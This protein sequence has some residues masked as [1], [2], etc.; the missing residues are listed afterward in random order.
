[1]FGFVLL[2]WYVHYEVICF[3]M[4]YCQQFVA[5]SII[6][7]G[8][9]DQLRCLLIRTFVSCWSFFSLTP[10][11]LIYSKVKLSLGASENWYYHILMLPDS[12]IY[13]CSRLPM[14]L[15]AWTFSCRVGEASHPGPKTIRLC[16]TNPTAIYKKVSDLVKFGGDVILASETSATIAVQST[17]QFEFAK[18]N[19]KSYFS[20]HVASK[21]ETSDLRPSFRGEP[22]GTAIFSKLP[23]RV[24]RVDIP[25]PLWDSQRFCCSIVRFGQLEVC[26]VSIYGFQKKTQNGKKVNDILLSY[27]YRVVKEIGLPYIISGDFNEPVDQ[28]PIFNLFRE[29][30]ATEAFY[31]YKCQTQVTLPPTCKGVTRNDSA[32]LHPLI[33]QR[34]VGMSVSEKH[35]IDV[36]SPLFVELDFEN[37]IPQVLSWKIPKSWAAMAPNKDLFAQ[38]YDHTRDKHQSMF[39]QPSSPEDIDTQLQHWSCAVEQAVD[40]AIQLQHKQ[41]PLKY[42]L[43]CLPGQ[44]KGRCVIQEL[45][46]RSSKQSC[47]HDPHGNFNPPSEV[48]SIRNKQKTRQVRRLKSL[49]RAYKATSVQNGLNSQDANVCWQ[50]QQEWFA[51][52]KARGYG[53]RWDHW[54]LSFELVP[55]VP[56]HLPEYSLLELMSDI[57]MY[58]C[59][60]SCKYETSQ[61]KQLF[62]H[63]IQVDNEHDFGKMTYRIMKSKPRASLD[64]VPMTCKAHGTLLRCAKGLPKIRIHPVMDL[65]PGSQIKYGNCV[66]K[67][68]KSEH[69]IVTISQLEG[70]VPAQGE[71]QFTKVA[72]T[73]TEIY[74]TFK[75]F[76][77]PMWMRDSYE[78]QFSPQ[79][80]NDFTEELNATALPHIPIEAKINDVSIW[81]DVIADLKS[82]K[83]HGA[84]G[85]RHEELK[86]LPKNA[87][88]DLACIFEQAMHHGLSTN[89]MK[90]R[91]ILLAKV[92]VPQSMHHARPITILGVLY[93]LVGKVIFKQIAKQMSYVLPWPISGGLP[94]RGVKDIAYT[95]KIVIEKSLKNQLQL[96]GFSL[97]LVKAFNTFGRYP[98]AQI[99]I[100]LGIPVWIVSFW[101]KSL[102][103]M[104]RYLDHGGTMSQAIPV[105]TG[106]PEGDS[107]SVLA[108]LS[109]SAFYYYRILREGVFPYAYADNWSWF[110]PCQRLHFRTFTC[111]LNMVSCLKLTIDFDKSWH[112]GTTKAFR[113]ACENFALLFP[114]QNIQTTVK[115]QV[116]D[117]GEMVNYNKSVS[118]GFIQDKF[119]E[120]VKVI[121]R[122]EWIPCSI[123]QKL[124]RIQ[125][126]A[127]PMAL[128]STDTT[129]V[130]PRHF[131]A[132]RRA[133][134]QAL[135]G[136]KLNA[137][138]WLASFVLSKTLQDPFLHVLCAITRCVRR[139][140]HTDIA[141]AK[142]IVSMACDFDKTR[143]YGPASA[144]KKYLQN[145][146]WEIDQDG[147]IYGPDHLKTNI[148]TDS[149]KD[150]KR[151]LG[152]GW[153]SYLIQNMDRKGVGDVSLHPQITASVFQSFSEQDQKLLIHN[154]LG[155]FQ[156]EKQKSFWDTKCTG[157]CVLCDGEDTHAHRLLECPH[158]EHIRAKHPQ[159]IRI[160]KEVRPEWCYLLLARQHPEVIVMRMILQHHSTCSHEL[161]NSSICQEHLCFYTDGGCQNPTC[162]EAKLASWAVVQDLSLTTDW[163]ESWFLRQS[164]HEG[165]EKHVQQNSHQVLGMGIVPG[166]QTG[167]RAELFAFVKALE[168]AHKHPNTDSVEFV[169]DAQYVC[170]SVLATDSIVTD[171]ISYKSS[172]V[173]LLEK[174]TH[175]WDPSRFFVTKV[176]SHRSFQD[177]QSNEDLKHIGGNDSAD[178]AATAALKYAP[179]PIRELTSKIANFDKIEKE[180]LVLVCNFLIEFNQ[181]RIQLIE[182]TKDKSGD[183][184]NFDTQDDHDHPQGLLPHNAMGPHAFQ[185][186]KLFAP[187]YHHKFEADVPT[188]CFFAIQQGANLAKAIVLWLSTLTWPSD[189]NED[190]ERSDDWGIS[191]FELVI[192][193]TLMMQTFFPVRIQGLGSTSVYVPYNSDDAILGYPKRR[194]AYTQ[195]FCLLKAV[196]SIQSVSQKVL[197][198]K[199][200]SKQCRSLSRLG[201]HEKFTGLPC[202]PGMLY[203]AQTMDIVWDYIQ[204]IGP[205][206]FLDRPL[207][208]PVQTPWT[209]FP[210]LDE[211]SP[212]LRYKN[213]LKILKQHR[214]LQHSP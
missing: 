56:E 55:F 106:A 28:L 163:N 93:R 78:S 91:T 50:L 155:A 76:W 154:F 60:S 173:D 188:E 205:N 166:N 68:L 165:L 139:I 37:R 130:G 161:S 64:E 65:Q 202:R 94:G 103:R 81:S 196:G 124:L 27:V 126:A 36:H 5:S 136:T 26:V 153:P 199:F 122:L 41:N 176:K 102:A 57:T 190:Y 117:L 69:D 140:A 108:M 75:S 111:V 42:P 157:T 119:D 203:Q 52:K 18:F 116:K 127:W 171:T 80:W 191:W 149:T 25:P 159:A 51:I 72:I 201:F 105:T 61:R 109:V 40:K 160:L 14:S 192:N 120:A 147:W 35:R 90:A 89:L 186:M 92:P 46:D 112:W 17:V 135:I 86:S 184:G 121:Q 3:C 38:M 30:G 107:L 67:V 45:Q 96:G 44:F 183:I 214:R 146:G 137:S 134:V 156:T 141:L 2:Q 162:A 174:I 152:K 142:D 181:H 70:I 23:S 39:D 63:K 34:V 148:L 204:K 151:I 32:I 211:I 110:T 145:Y 209:T 77:S 158:L 187:Q 101:Q 172:N 212:D 21:I 189:I 131:H 193:F 132:L 113:D 128:Y 71:V 53:N 125:T 59:E 98:I 10:S 185:A 207:E 47:K 213:Y 87:I 13:L 123:S 143:P 66:A 58:D 82:G 114:G 180:N 73:P 9:S 197:L 83:A 54:I 178:Q 20:Q 99:M 48:F 206:G 177:A 208:I 29:E 150:I 19:F 167:A 62:Q 11:N 138:P 168:E 31:L 95:Q 43:P 144:L 129:F 1:M 85:W 195:S 8:C 115:S 169:T 118:L 16:I 12:A 194:A 104:V 6:S 79:D 97:D 179:K 182:K 210:P 84:C 15:H 4:V 74:D 100:R 88:A 175:L 198:P 170:N 7:V 33:A 133:L 24:A 22:L 49:L 164:G 200:K